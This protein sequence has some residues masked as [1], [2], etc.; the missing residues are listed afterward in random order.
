MPEK[1]QMKLKCL[2][3]GNMVI[4]KLGGSVIT[5]KKELKTPNLDAIQRLAKEIADA[6]P[7][8]LIVVHGGGSFGHPWAK[9]HKIKE[10]YQHPSQ[11]EWF[12]KIHQAMLE[13]NKL[14]VDALIRNNIAAFSISP[15]SCITTKAGRIQTFYDNTITRLLQIGFVPVL[16]G[17]TVLD[18]ELGFTILSGDQLAAAL[19]LKFKAKSVIFGVDVDGLFSADPKTNRKAQLVHRIT[20]PKL[21]TSIKNVEEAKVSDVTGGMLGK[22]LELKCAIDAS[23]KASI[24]N[25]TV[26]DNIYKA[27]RGERVIGTLI[28]KE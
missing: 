17:D 23:V 22:I 26:E 4:L 18:S 3:E 12:T 25:A 24:V 8:H 10:G 16:F 11:V 14:V 13:L 19:S 20:L 1:Q 15:S 7:E 6:K 2:T 5:N 9:E 21:K 27:L 28:E